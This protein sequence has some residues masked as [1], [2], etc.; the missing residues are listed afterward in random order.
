MSVVGDKLESDDVTL[1]LDEYMLLGGVCLLTTQVESRCQVVPGLEGIPTGYSHLSYQ[2]LTTRLQNPG[3]GW[4]EEYSISA[5]NFDPVQLIQLDSLRLTTGSTLVHRHYTLEDFKTTPIS[6]NFLERVEK[7]FATIREAGFMVVLRFSYKKGLMGEGQY[8]DATKD[9]MKVHISQLKPLFWNYRGI[10]L[11]VQAGF[12]GTWGEWYYTDHFGYP[13]PLNSDNYKDRRE[14][15][16]SLL[17]AVPDDLQIQL[18]APVFKREMY[19]YQPTSI[20]DLL[21]YNRK[22]NVKSRI[23]H[24]NDCFLA[25][26]TDRGTYS[27]FNV[28]FN[29][30]REDTTHVIMGGETCALDNERGRHVCS[31]AEQELEALHF[32]FLSQ[33]YHKAVLSNWTTDGCYDLFAAKLGYTMALVESVLPDTVVRGGEFSYYILL[34]NNGY[35]APA[36]DMN[37]YLVL[38]SSTNGIY[39]VPLETNTRLWIPNKDIVL[40]GSVEVPRSVTPASYQM[41]MAIGD[42]QLTEES[43]YYVLL[44]NNMVPS[45]DMGLNNLT[46]PITVVEGTPVVTS[47]CP[48]FEPWNPPQFAR[49]PRILESNACLKTRVLN[50]DFEDSTSWSGLW[51][52]FHYRQDAAQAYSGSGYIEVVD[53]PEGGGSYQAFTFFDKPTVN[54]TRMAIKAWGK[55]SGS[56][57]MGSTN[58]SLYCDVT[59]QDESGTYGLNRPFLGGQQG[60]TWNSVIVTIDQPKGIRAV[61]CY[62]LYKGYNGGSAYFDKVDVWLLSGTTGF[63][64]CQY[65]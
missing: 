25:D 9:I 36:K 11:A 10:I 27:N 7:D 24:H 1:R 60:T 56:V 54:L 23:G 65:T 41:W 61:T 38:M 19:S 16:E 59:L 35:A 37:V 26:S 63:E 17:D 3:R 5:T 22:R 21:Q 28:E 30:M 20:V 43:D 62:L 15:V 14:I 12:I 48:S 47:N 64:E 34:R 2:P 4:S 52:G 58:F 49:H 33:S 39:K 42:K 53:T 51:N 6:P 13:P 29:Y 18:R 46:H 57:G 32:T 40:R 45:P 8:G 44:A 50:H 31:N 55:H